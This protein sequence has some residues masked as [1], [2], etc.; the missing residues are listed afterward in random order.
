M[1]LDFRLYILLICTHVAVA[2]REVVV[3]V[4]TKYDDA[5]WRYI[6]WANVTTVVNTKGNVSTGL[7]TTAHEHGAQVLWNVGPEIIEDFV[8]ATPGDA[9]SSY[10]WQ[11]DLTN[12][13]AR[14]FAAAALARGIMRAGYDGA[15]LDVESNVLSPNASTWT[16]VTQADA[17]DAFTAFVSEL[18][19]ALDVWRRVSGG[20]GG[21]NATLATRAATRRNATLA[22][23]STI[24]PNATGSKGAWPYFDLPALAMQVDWFFAMGYG[25]QHLEAGQVAS[26]NSDARHLVRGIA[27]YAALGIDTRRQL[28]LGLPWYGTDNACAPGAFGSACVKADGARIERPLFNWT[29]IGGKPGKAGFLGVSLATLARDPGAE[30]PAQWDNAS[31]SPYFDYTCVD[32]NGSTGAGAAT[33]CQIWYDNPRSLRAKAALAHDCRGVGAFTVDFGGSMAAAAARPKE[34]IACAR[35]L[36]DALT[37]S[38]GPAPA[39]IGT[40]V[41]KDVHDA[42]WF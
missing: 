29:S 17:R 5:S 10:T 28:V 21:T 30:R 25:M 6:P 31:L 7:V 34:D 11:K 27:G 39:G 35:R 24:Y 38:P 22:M 37:G 1:V 8:R 33:R 13:T 12:T 32:R 3:Y 42:C 14:R 15:V 20:G 23:A 19:A 26:S 36:W 2:R 18:R 4:E 41:K 16:N 40:K 9:W